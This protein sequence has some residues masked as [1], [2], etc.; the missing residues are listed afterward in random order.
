MKHAKDCFCL[1][2]V[3]GGLGKPKFEAEVEAAA[4]LRENLAWIVDFLESYEVFDSQGKSLTVDLSDFMKHARAIL[5]KTEGQHPY[6]L[7]PGDMD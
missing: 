6:Y 5:E 3:V 4:V 1:H 2:C 7:C